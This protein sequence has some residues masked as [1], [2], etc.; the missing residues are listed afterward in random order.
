MCEEQDIDFY[1][2]VVGICHAGPRVLNAWMV[3][4][5]WAVAYRRYGGGLDDAE[6]TVAWVAQRGIWS[7]KFVMPWHWRH[8]ER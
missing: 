3:K 6:E 8:G 4:S 1:R 2:R 7:G 5:G